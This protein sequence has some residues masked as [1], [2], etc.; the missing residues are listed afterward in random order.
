M[1]IFYDLIF[2]VFALIYLPVYLFRR[3]FHPG[4]SMRLGILPKAL[5]FNRP[6]WIHAVSVGEVMVVQKL[7]AGLKAA[8]PDKKILISTVTPTGNRIARGI[9]AG[10]DAVIYLPL[11]LSFIVR[12]VVEKINPSLFIM[13][14]TEIWPNLISYLAQKKIP[15]LLV[16]GRISDRSFRGYLGIKFLLKPLLNKISL[17]CVQTKTDAQRL[18][19]LGVLESRIQIAGNMKFDILDY[20]DTT[21]DYPDYKLKLGLGPEEKLLV[22]GSTHPGEEEII[23]AI[24][25]RLL[26]EFPRLKLLIAPRHPERAAQIEKLVIRHNLKPIKILQLNPTPNTN[27]LKPVFILNTIGQLLNFY[28]IAD[29]VFVGGSLIRKGG[30]NILEPAALSKPVIFGPYMFNF[31][32]ISGLFLENKAALLARDKEELELYIKDLLNNPA[33][34]IGLSQRAKSLILQNQGA[35]ARNLEYISNY[36]S[37]K[38]E[39]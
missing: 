37:K 39:D 23:L 10:D 35:T 25:R 4:F 38:K 9:A 27:N 15:V 8:Y 33:K 28:N 31:R 26:S 24:Y 3:K 32:D 5:E 17:F 20:A 11:D 13:A 36:L 1:F 30:H 12:H 16:N 29:I 2:L 6:I 18:M 21:K 19:R 14:E 22:A 34:G 7:I